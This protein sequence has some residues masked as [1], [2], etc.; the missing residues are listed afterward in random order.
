MCCGKSGSGAGGA[1]AYQMTY[2]DAG[3]TQHVSYA[4]NLGAYAM[5]RDQV[6]ADGGTV[7]VGKQVPRAEYDEWE[8]RQHAV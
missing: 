1:V 6:Q 3:G 8:A 2:T 7:V 5:L 4:V